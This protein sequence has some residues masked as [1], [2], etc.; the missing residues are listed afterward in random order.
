MVGSPNNR[1]ISNT[2]KCGS[3]VLLLSACSVVE[4]Y[5]GGE[6]SQRRVILGA[7]V[8]SVE[9]TKEGLIKQT[10]VRALGLVNSGNRTTVGLTHQNVFSF[11]HQC[12]A[13]FVEP[14]AETV[15]LIREAMPDLDEVCVTK[16]Q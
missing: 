7:P 12:G 3:L 5:D 4:K 16:R 11:P 15:A 13:V 1:R 6:L 14:D 10:N 2:V 8:V 9:S